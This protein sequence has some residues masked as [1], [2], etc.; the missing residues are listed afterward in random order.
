ME[1]RIVTRMVRGP[2][3]FYEGVRAMLIDRDG[4]PNWSPANLKEVRY[5]KH[6]TPATSIKITVIYMLPALQERSMLDV[7]S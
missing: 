2:S 6:H 4:K 7:V 1:N 3:D 5:F